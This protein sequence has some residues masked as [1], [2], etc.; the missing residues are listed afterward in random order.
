M[1]EQ[2]T[3]KEY[4]VAVRG[5]LEIAT[6]VLAPNEG[7]ARQ[8]IEDNKWFDVYGHLEGE[9]GTVCVALNRD[10]TLEVVKVEYLRELPP[11]P[12]PPPNLYDEAIM[13]TLLNMLAVCLDKEKASYDGSP[14]HAYHRLYAYMQTLAAMWKA[15][16]LK[17]VL[18]LPSPT[19]LD[20][21]R[22]KEALELSILNAAS[23]HP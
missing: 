17:P 20:A 9:D 6:Q 2:E 21:E 23:P 5:Q 19:E 14:D 13:R 1:T 4:R 3:T 16:G 7:S 10:M 22:D 12:P 8:S 11:R 18:H 15:K